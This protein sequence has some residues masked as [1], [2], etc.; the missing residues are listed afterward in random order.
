[1]VMTAANQ[2]GLYFE[3]HLIVGPGAQPFSFLAHGV[4]T[5]APK[6]IEMAVG[7]GHRP[8]V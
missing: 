8:G 6:T 7:P 5:A 1:M 2:V 3:D 4:I